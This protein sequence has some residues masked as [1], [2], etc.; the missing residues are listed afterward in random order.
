MERFGWEKPTA[1]KLVAV[2]SASAQ[3]STI[4]LNPTRKEPV[5]PREP[6]GHSQ[7]AEMLVTSDNMLQELAEKET[8]NS[9]NIR[10][11]YNA[12]ASLACTSDLWGLSINKLYK[13]GVLGTQVI[14]GC[15]ATH[16]VG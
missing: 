11:T 4:N 6:V 7:P 5:G 8:A 3:H 10:D 15:C 13:T 9:C 12:K 14:R 16:T 1:R 2:S